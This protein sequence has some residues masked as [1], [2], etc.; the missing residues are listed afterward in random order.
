MT[1]QQIKQDLAKLKEEAANKPDLW[2]LDSSKTEIE[3]LKVK[4]E[5][6]KEIEESKTQIQYYIDEG[7][8][9]D[10]DDHTINMNWGSDGIP[11]FTPNLI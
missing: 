9:G 4:E 10:E 5:I 6:I 11:T 1:I 7:V 2:L 8:F 3:A